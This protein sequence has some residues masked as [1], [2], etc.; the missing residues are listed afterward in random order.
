MRIRSTKP[1]FWR[2]KRIAEVEWEARFVLKGLESYVDDNGVGKDDLELMV[3]DLFSRDLARDPSRT[4]KRVQ[5]AVSTLSEAGLVHRYADNGTDLIYIAW[6]E[7][8]Q[9]INRPTKGRFRRPDGTWNYGESEI[10]AFAP[11]DSRAFKSPQSLIRGSED[12]GIRE[13][14]DQGIPPTADEAPPSSALVVVAPDETTAQTLVAEWIDHCKDRPPGR[15]IGQVSRELKAMLDEGV[16][17]TRLRAALAEWNRKGLHP[18]TLASVV[19]EITNRAP[20]ARGQQA[21]NDLFD[22]AMER[23]IERDRSA[24]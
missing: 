11:E 18:S 2:S 10:G 4:L 23:A 20:A 22:A 21:T 7:S 5:A 16:D 3:G 17:P 6:W 12:Q 19:H 1:E 8:V 14:G 15:V 24:S 9:Y 13:T